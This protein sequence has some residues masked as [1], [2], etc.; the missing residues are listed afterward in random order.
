MADI[1][2]CSGE[3]N[4][5]TCPIRDKCYRFTAPSTEY[6]QSFFVDMPGNYIEENGKS[7]WI[8]D[9]YWGET[10]ESILKVFNDMFQ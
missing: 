2:K 4:G 6:W 5:I 1:T 10:Q 7:V 3:Q 9:V 8:C